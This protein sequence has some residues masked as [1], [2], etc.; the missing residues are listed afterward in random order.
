MLEEKSFI[1][2]VCGHQLFHKDLNELFYGTRDFLVQ[3]GE[4]EKAHLVHQALLKMQGVVSEME[5]CDA[6]DKLSIR[7]RDDVISDLNN[8][9]NKLVI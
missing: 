4:N 7:T 2:D 3:I 1:L 6:I 9:L 5:M 8:I